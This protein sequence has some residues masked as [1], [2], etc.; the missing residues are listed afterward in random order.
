[1]RVE[2]ESALAGWTRQAVDAWSSAACG[3]GRFEVSEGSAS[4]AADGVNSVTLDPEAVETP[5]GARVLGAT[6]LRCD[7]A[8]RII[9]ADVVLYGSDFAE[10]TA[11]SFDP[12]GVLVHEL[13]HVLGREHTDAAVDSVMIA[14][15]TARR[16]IEARRTGHDDAAWLCRDRGLSPERTDAVSPVECGLFAGLCAA[17]DRDDSCGDNGGICVLSEPSGQRLCGRSCDHASDPCPPGF[18]CV[19]VGGERRAC[20]PEAGSCDGV[21]GPQQR[22]CEASD[23]AT[24]GIGRCTASPLGGAPRCEQPCGLG[25][26][27]EASCIDDLGSG[28]PGR[29][30]SGPEL[31]PGHGGEG[32]S[33]ARGA[34]GP[35]WWLAPL[36]LG[37]AGRLCRRH[38]AC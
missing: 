7:A 28:A 26:A 9:E 35:A 12:V 4:F 15:T 22:P 31:Q 29:W 23:A 6:C 33:T 19:A 34:A 32:C 16:S 21:T 10:C 3:E 18:A 11:E 37:L 24:C 25:I 2:P 8:G 20:V 14:A 1:M 5:S 36:V 17:C 30:C 38:T 13:G 27:C